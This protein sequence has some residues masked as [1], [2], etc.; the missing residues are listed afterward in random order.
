MLLTF[1]RDFVAHASIA[2]RIS[3]LVTLAKMIQVNHKRNKNEYF[4]L[5]LNRRK[6]ENNA[7]QRW[8]NIKEIIIINHK[9]T[10]VVKDGED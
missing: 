10:R 5:P 9:G 1:F 8:K 3:V 4:K 6:P 2:C 7:S